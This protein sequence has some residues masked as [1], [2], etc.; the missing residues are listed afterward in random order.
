[1]EE[2]E[3]ELVVKVEEE[4]G[5]E[6]EEEEVDI[7]PWNCTWLITFLIDP[8]VPSDKHHLVHIPQ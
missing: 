6:K 3:E 5:E 8:D 1:M 4:E 7:M 2:E